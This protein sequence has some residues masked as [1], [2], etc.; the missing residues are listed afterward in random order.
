MLL[1]N[2]F[3]GCSF[4]TRSTQLEQ[5]TH[6]VVE[7]K[8]IQINNKDFFQLR[9]FEIKTHF[10]DVDQ[11]T[12]TE[13]LNYV[14]ATNPQG[15][16]FGKSHQVAE[17][18]YMYLDGI[19]NSKAIGGRAIYMETYTIVSD[20]Y[21]LDTIRDRYFNNPQK[22]YSNIIKTC[23]VGDWHQ[24]DSNYIVTFKTFKSAMFSRR[25]GKKVF[26]LKGRYITANDNSHS[27]MSFEEITHPAVFKKN[28]SIV[29]LSD[30]EY[31]K[32]DDVVQLDTIPAKV[33]KEIYGV[34]SQI[35]PG[36]LF[37]NI[38]KDKNIIISSDKE[39]LYSNTPLENKI[40]SFLIKDGNLYFS[41]G[42]QTYLHKNT[43]FKSY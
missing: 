15:D 43:E 11:T 5:V 8:E 25:K 41:N 40:N 28:E 26:K 17:E 20:A 29:S 14:Q 16:P 30:L 37:Y 21:H 3:F 19:S 39:V 23:Y 34:N 13:Y 12:D 4:Y 27:L 36:L 31:V 7:P 18:T 33:L 35:I 10:I 2:I 24:E 6:Q 1:F 22:I 42:F 9:I 38:P 32:L